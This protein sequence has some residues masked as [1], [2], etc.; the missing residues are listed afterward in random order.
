[1]EQKPG[2]KESDES[3]YPVKVVQNPYKE[4]D[5]SGESKER[6]LIGGTCV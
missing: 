4:S 6:I 2:G 3:A 5:E 1:M